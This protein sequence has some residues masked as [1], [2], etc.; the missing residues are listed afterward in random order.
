MN[1][2][3]KTTI[4]KYN[5]NTNDIIQ[6][7]VQA[8]PIA[9]KQFENS[10]LTPYTGDAITDAK[11]ACMYVRNNVQYKADGFRFQDIQ[12]PGR[13]F[14]QT[15]QA[16]CKSFS[17]AVLANLLSKGYKGGFR[18]AAYRGGKIP[19]HVYIYVFDKFGKKFTFDPCIKDLKE[20][21][22]ASN[23]IDMDVRYLSGLED[24]K[25]SAPE[26][27][28]R[29]YMERNKRRANLYNIKTVQLPNDLNSYV[30][31]AIT[32]RAERQARR[33]AR[34]ERREERREDRQERRQ[35]RRENRQERRQERREERKAG[36]GAVKKVTLAPVR[37]AF[38]GLVA[39]NVRGLATKINTLISKGD[40][41]IKEFWLKLGGKYD[42]LVDAVNSGKGKKALF[43][44][45][46]G[47]NG[48]NQT[49]YNEE[50]IG[51][52]TL[53]TAAAA[54][55]AAAPALLA[56]SNLFKKKGVPEG[57]GDV[58]TSQEKSTTE[59]I[60]A[61]GQPFQASDDENASAMSFKPS[62]MLIGGAIA[63]AGLI[64]FL[65]K[66]KR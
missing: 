21:P 65:T 57:E 40:K 63:A 54:I 2:D 46:K 38:L 35:E 66:K 62:P 11:A 34:R 20:S 5:A 12:L 19:T 60:A 50:G 26:E 13:M 59:P 58:I 22:K 15:K 37:G 39:L 3:G 1:F 23:I 55:A 30:T 42:K 27:R 49:E 51:A 14:K 43:G 41:D 6:S 48:A 28:P 32:G 24:T 10:I 56:I 47:V 9:V 4:V 36:G 31:E 33:E 52:V 25:Y 61:D 29:R 18:F 44:K 53:A 64:Y 17:L 16:D 8:V 7:L 45:G